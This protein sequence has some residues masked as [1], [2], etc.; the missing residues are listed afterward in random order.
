MLYSGAVVHY[1]AAP[2]EA[3]KSGALGARPLWLKALG[4]RGT[5]LI[6]TQSAAAEL[7]ASHPRYL[8][9]GKVAVVLGAH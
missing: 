3:K 5:D 9:E 2:E 1:F 4:A 8:S 7:R 6:L